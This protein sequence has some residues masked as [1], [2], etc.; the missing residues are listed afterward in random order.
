MNTKL[1]AV[2][3]AI[4]TYQL[5]Y[6]EDA[7]VLIFDTEKV[8]GYKAGK[9][10]DLKIKLGETVEQHKNTTSV[11]A[12]KSGKHI[13]EERGPELF[14]F[15]YIASAV[16]IFDNGQVVGVCT[17]VISNDT[18]SE[19]RS[20]S[21]A[22]S[23]SVAEMS[24]TTDELTNASVNVSKQLEELSHLAETATQDIQQ[25]NSIVRSVKDI[26]Q[27]SKILGLNAGIE[28]A[29]SG[30]HGRGFAIV[31]NEIQ[32]MAQDSNQSADI[33]TKELEN[34]KQSIEF[35]NNSTSQ[36]SSFTQE[37]TANMQQMS[38]TYMN[39]NNVGQKLLKLSNIK[40]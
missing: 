19:L 1:K 40:C 28:A 22:L 39:L 15:A 35:I 24:V 9:T 38:H 26:A 31:A 5:T 21:N 29:R 16:P 32:K 17:G 12:L 23:E 4:D 34:I 8:V 20:V 13:R 30:V 10:V 3:D 6:P 14:G 36:I 33:I 18:I 27:K 7:C 25:I 37:Y 11:R 2:V